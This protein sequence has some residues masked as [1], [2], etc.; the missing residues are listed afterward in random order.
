MV[1]CP[2]HSELTQVQNCLG[3]SFCIIFDLFIAD[4][5][6]NAT[7]LFHIS[8]IGLQLETISRNLLWNCNAVLQE[9]LAVEF[10]CLKNSLGYKLF[11]L[12]LVDDYSGMNI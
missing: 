3:S 5:I 12:L 8:R 7:L 4:L 2:N 11:R 6:G 10:A 9:F 1:R